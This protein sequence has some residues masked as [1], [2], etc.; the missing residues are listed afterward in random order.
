MNRHVRSDLLK[1]FFG[2]NFKVI[3]E[4]IS[5]LVGV[6]VFCLVVFTNW[7]DM[8]EAWR[9][10]EWEGEGTLRVPVAP[11]RTILVVGSALTALYYAVHC[12]KCV[13]QMATRR[14]KAE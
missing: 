8:M 2:P 4:I 9:M 3:M 12:Y 5:P 6:A 13:A 14:R 1:S 10:G 11:F 7:H